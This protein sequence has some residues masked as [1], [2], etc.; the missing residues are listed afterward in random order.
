[1]AVKASK[2]AVVFGECGLK[3][4]TGPGNTERSSRQT[5]DD[6]TETQ[7]TSQ[8]KVIKTLVKKLTI[9]EQKPHDFLQDALVLSEH[10]RRVYFSSYSIRN[11]RGLSSPH[12]GIG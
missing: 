7:Y 6:M 1:V 12:A 4:F 9:S 2:M 11:Q 10:V 3:C 8:L 5:A